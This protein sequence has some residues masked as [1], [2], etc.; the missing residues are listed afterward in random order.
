[1]N[2]ETTAQVTLNGSNVIRVFSEGYAPV[3]I[4][5]KDLSIHENEKNTT[6][7]PA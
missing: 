6:A 2:L 7:A 4:D 1:M 3:E 5:L